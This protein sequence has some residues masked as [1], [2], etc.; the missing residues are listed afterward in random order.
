MGVKIFALVTV[1]C[2]CKN[3]YIRRQCN[4]WNDNNSTKFGFIPKCNDFTN[5]L[6]KKPSIVE[7]ML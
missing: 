2:L 6:G 3:V 5:M 1:K 4:R 7:C